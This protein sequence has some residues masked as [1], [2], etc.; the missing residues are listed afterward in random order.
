MIWGFG[1]V[2]IYTV[3]KHQSSLI[4]PSTGFGGVYIYTVTKRVG[5]IRP[6]ADCFGRVY[7]YIVVKTIVELIVKKQ[8]EYN[9]L[10]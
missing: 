3:T 6:K 7:I 9:I 2:Y 8:K 4:I 1:R 5:G 10:I